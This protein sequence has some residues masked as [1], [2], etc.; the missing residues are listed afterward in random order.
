MLLQA[1]LI[2]AMHGP[3]KMLDS[4]IREHVNTDESFSPE[5]MLS[6]IENINDVRNICAHNNRLLGYN[7]RHDSKYWAPLHSIYGI[8]K[9]D[10]RRSIFSVLILLRCFLSKTE[11]AT[12]HNRILEESKRLNNRLK[13]ICP[14]EIL[15]QLGF[16][17]NWQTKT[18]KVYP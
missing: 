7:C 6:F 12:L 10:S 8:A 16:P 9:N 4:F 18:E 15:K 3:L 5:I 13:S 14:N 1:V 11:Y 2:S 17:E